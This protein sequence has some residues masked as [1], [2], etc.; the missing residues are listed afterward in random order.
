M[1]RSR[2]AD[3]DLTATTRDP[4]AQVTISEIMFDA[5]QALESRAMDRTL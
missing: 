2:H 1:M 5:G 4:G 3:Y